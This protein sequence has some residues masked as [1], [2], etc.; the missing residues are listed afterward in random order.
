MGRSGLV[1]W[2]FLGILANI[3][4]PASSRAAEIIYD[5]PEDLKAT[6]PATSKSTAQMPAPAEDQ[7]AEQQQP[8]ATLEQTKERF[9]ELEKQV[10][11]GTDNLDTYFEYAQVAAS[12]GKNKEAISKCYWRPNHN[13]FW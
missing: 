1:I 2:I 6:E 9:A 7:P 12:L 5:S 10:A 8:P 11:E 3:Y 13:C 4:L